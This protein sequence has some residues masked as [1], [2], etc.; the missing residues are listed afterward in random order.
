MESYKILLYIVFGTLPSLTWLFYYLQKDLHPEP[1]KMILKIFLLGAFATIPTLFIQIWLSESLNAF[2]YLAV[3]YSP[4]IAPYLPPIFGIIKWFFIIALTEELLKFAM[5]RLAFFN[6]GQMDEPLDLML[7][8][9]VSAL[10]FAA[11]ENMLYIFS[12]VNN[13]LS[14]DQIIK[15]TITISFIRFVGATFLHTLCSALVG[16]FLALSSLKNGHGARFTLFGIFLATLLHGLY[17]FSIMTLSAPFNFLL[18][19]GILIGLA[20]FMV[21]DFDEIKKIKGICKI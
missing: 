11:V 12:P 21:Y 8:M 7:Y 9:V 19:I 18:P 15:T 1:K 17:N 14:L 2:Q 13:M 3:F 5:V 20:V 4:G 16:Y 6:D 10:G